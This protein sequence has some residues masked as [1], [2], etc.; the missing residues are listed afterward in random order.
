[1]PNAMKPYIPSAK[2]PGSVQTN[3]YQP[4]P[5]AGKVPDCDPT[6]LMLMLNRTA[7]AFP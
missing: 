6:E 2:C 7:G 1:M 4:G 3:S 5:G